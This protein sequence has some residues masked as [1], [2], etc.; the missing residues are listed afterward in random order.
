M[1]RADARRLR[2]E[3]EGRDT[4]APERVGS[5][6]AYRNP[7]MTVREDVLRRPDGSDGIYGVVDKPDFVLVLPLEL[8]G[9][10]IVEQYRYPVGGRFWEFPQGS[11]TE[12][13]PDRPDDA[14]ALARAELREETGL[15]A[16]SLTWL[17]RLHVAHGYSSQGCNVFLAE[18]LTKRS[19]AREATE[20]D[21]IRRWVSGAELD[22]M[23]AA[24]DFV[25][26][27]SLAA[28]TLLRRHLGGTAHG[29]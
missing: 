12:Q 20:A 16:R 28:L 7:W 13:D 15:V 9:F 1:R 23:I 18:D 2:P 27:P 3:P 14:A 26:G 10:Y 17:G 22:E 4:G 5:R 8:D 19:P 6:M 11:W 25:D 29:R 24:G 21:M